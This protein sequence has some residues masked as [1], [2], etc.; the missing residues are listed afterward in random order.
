MKISNLVKDFERD[1]RFERYSERSVLNY[2]CQIKMFLGHFKDKD[3]C[4]HIS[5]NEIKDYLLLSNKVNSQNHAHSAIKLFYRMT[6]KQPMKF[7]HIKYAK[8]EQKLPQPLSE[9]EVQSLFAACT[10]LKH[11]AI[12]ALLFGCGMRVGEVL[13][14]KPEHIDRKRGVIN[15]IAGKG[16]KDRIVPMGAELLNLLSKYWLEYRPKE[17]MFNGQFGVQYSMSSI[18]QFLKQ[19][20]KKAGVNKNIHSHLGRHSYSSQLWANGIDLAK[21]KEILG[22]KSEKTTRIYTKCTSQIISSI[23]SPYSFV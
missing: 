1:M 4:K 7:H 20:A 9:S 21:I 11:R 8:K 18:N 15:I 23:R 10:N 13:N 5:A 12:M 2:G 19:I 17:Y 3:S 6:I 16:N 22:H 14:L